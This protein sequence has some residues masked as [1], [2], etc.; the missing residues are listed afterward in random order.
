VAV[1]R[2]EAFII[3]RSATSVID[4]PARKFVRVASVAAVVVAATQSAEADGTARRNIT[5]T[6]V[7]VERVCVPSATVSHVCSPPADSSN[8]PAS[9]GFH[10]AAMTGTA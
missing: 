9:A 7:I 6:V 10:P 2:R 5:V 1:A 3:R 4:K 8:N